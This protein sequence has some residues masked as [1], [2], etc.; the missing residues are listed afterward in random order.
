VLSEQ[1]WIQQ[2]RKIPVEM[3]W[4]IILS[5]FLTLMLTLPTE[6]GNVLL[7]TRRSPQD[8]PP[9]TAEPGDKPPVWCSF[10]LPWRGV[11]GLV[12]KRCQELA[13]VGATRK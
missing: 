12:D 8:A 10:A 9:P 13:G 5:Q 3:K 1:L 4:M 7:R 2:L 6:G 11:S